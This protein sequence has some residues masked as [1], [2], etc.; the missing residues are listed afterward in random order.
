[1]NTLLSISA[2]AFRVIPT[3]GDHQ[4]DLL[5]ERR[6]SDEMRLEFDDQN[7]RTLSE[8]VLRG[9]WLESVANDKRYQPQYSQ[10][11]DPRNRDAISIYQ[12][13]GAPGGP[14]SSGRLIDRY[15]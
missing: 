6:A 13:A 12:A 3:Q 4:Q 1:M 14:G 5:K 2:S 11:I 7:R 8:P 9:E 15:I 10:N